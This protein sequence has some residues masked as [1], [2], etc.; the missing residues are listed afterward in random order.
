MAWRWVGA[1]VFLGGVAVA[2][3]CESDELGVPDVAADSSDTASGDVP[4][5]SEDSGLLDTRPEDTEPSDVSDDTEPVDTSDTEIE[6]T[7]LEDTE[8][9]DVEPG[10][11][12]DT[13]SAD[14]SGDTE[15]SDT[16]VGDTEPVDTG[17]GDTAD[18]EP[19]DTAGPA[20]VEVDCGAVTPDATVSI[21]SAAFSPGSTTISVGDVVQWTNNDAIPHTVTAGSSGSPNP[22]LFHSGTL[23]QT[24]T[25]CLR[26]DVAGSY[27]FYCQ[28][29]TSM[30]GSVTVE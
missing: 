10:D 19:G 24:D 18:A 4:T 9:G 29:H 3:G 11:A 22:D 12:S 5:D 27:P 7:E 1:I 6:D 23:S 21:A 8:P 25:V 30:T 2:T 20:V 26:F 17:T 15:P 13:E 14:T 16:G 28:I